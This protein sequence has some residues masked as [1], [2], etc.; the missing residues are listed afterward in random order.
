MTGNTV[1]N[2]AVYP[3]LHGINRIKLGKGVDDTFD[4]IFFFTAVECRTLQ[5]LA[6][7][8]GAKTAFLNVDALHGSTFRN[9]GRKRLCSRTG[10][11]LLKCGFCQPDLVNDASCF[12]GQIFAVFIDEIER[13]FFIGDIG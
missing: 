11:Q 8:Y 5:L 13:D 4:H 6:E 2:I 3:D 1:Y 12:Y 9:I 7:I 10:K